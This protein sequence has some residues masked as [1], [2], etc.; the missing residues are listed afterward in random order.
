MSTSLSPGASRTPGPRQSRRSARPGAT[1][2]HC[3]GATV[4]RPAL[5]GIAQCDRPLLAIG[6]RRYSTSSH[7][8]RDEELPRCGR[9]PGRER[10]V[11]LASTA[12]VG[13]PFDL[14]VD[15]AILLEPRGLLAQ[16]VLGFGAQ[17][18]LIL[19]K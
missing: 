4:L 12:L 14:D 3:N 10:D 15:V 9:A 6:D 5:F 18:G 7:A 8:L 16:R 11:V 19:G 17:G 13:M 2:D 1:R